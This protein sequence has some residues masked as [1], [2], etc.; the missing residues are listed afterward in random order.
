MEVRVIQGQDAYEQQKALDYKI[1]TWSEYVEVLAEIGWVVSG[2]MKTKSGQN[3]CHFA[4]TE[5]V[6]IAEN[7]QYCR[8]IETCASKLNVVSQSK[9]QQQAQKI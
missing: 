9:K 8:D 6:K 7:I 2:L 3:F 4:C 1:G 5:D